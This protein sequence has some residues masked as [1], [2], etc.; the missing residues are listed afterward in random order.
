MC[1]R[2]LTASLVER[3]GAAFDGFLD[4]SGDFFPTAPGT[5]WSWRAAIRPD[6]RRDH[7][8]FESLVEVGFARLF[9]HLISTSPWG[10]ETVPAHAARAFPLPKALAQGTLRECGSNI[11]L[12]I[13]TLPRER[14]FLRPSM[15]E[16]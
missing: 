8:T 14:G 16:A 6:W 5:A 4:H 10:H 1:E 7:G 3:I 13:C 9:Q 2:W 11:R 12:E 15:P